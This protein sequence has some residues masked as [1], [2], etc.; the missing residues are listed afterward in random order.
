MPELLR[1][2]AVAAGTTEAV[3]SSWSVAE[4]ATVAA[5]DVVATVETAKAVVDV[6]AEADGVVLPPGRHVSSNVAARFS[7]MKE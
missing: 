3:L 2:P 5:H 1:M 4:N 6:E 7:T